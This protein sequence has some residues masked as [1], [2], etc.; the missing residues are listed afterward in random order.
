MQALQAAWEKKEKREFLRAGTVAAAVYNTVRD[1]K[2]RAE[3]FTAK[4][5][6]P[7]LTPSAERSEPV[8]A[9]AAAIDLFFSGVKRQAQKA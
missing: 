2:R 8:S 9:E 7:V 3:A 6:F 5:V 1:S 4:D